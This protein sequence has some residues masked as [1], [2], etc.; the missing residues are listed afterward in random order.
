MAFRIRKKRRGNQKAKQGN[1]VS[2]RNDKEELQ[3]LA[4]LDAMAES[5][6]K[7]ERVESSLDSIDEEP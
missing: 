6:R 1:I 5:S 7:P 4:E 2:P 3:E